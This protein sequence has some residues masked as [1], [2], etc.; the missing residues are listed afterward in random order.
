VNSLDCYYSYRFIGKLTTFFP[1]SGVQFVETD[2]GLFHF[3]RTAFS[4]TLKVKV[5]KVGST[6]VKDTALRI[7][8]NIDCTTISSRTHTHPSHSQTSRLLNSSLS[9]G[10]PVPRSSQCIRGVCRFL[11]FSFSLSSHRH[12]Y[13]GLVFRSRFFDS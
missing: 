4:D 7:T 5:F 1:D 6:R 2:R 10:V 11:R 9:L 12:S 8:L 3:R 13:T